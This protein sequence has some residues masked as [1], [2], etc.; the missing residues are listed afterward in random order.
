VLFHLCNMENK[1]NILDYLHFHIPTVEQKLALEALAQF[2]DIANKED[3]FILSGAAGTGKTS[4]TSALV[5]YLNNDI[6]YR[7]IAPTGRAARI[8]G[9]KTKCVSS[10]IHSLIYTPESN[11]E[12]G[13]VIWRLKQNFNDAYTVFIIDE[14]S[15]IASSTNNNE[16]FQ[17]SDSLLNHLVKFI[18]SGNPKNKIV[19]LGDKNQL[20]PYAE[21]DSLALDP[22]YMRKQY[23]FTGSFHY[24]TEVKRVEDGSY[25]LKNATRLRKSIEDNE[26]NIPKLEANRFNNTWNAAKDFASNYDPTNIDQLVAIGR[27]HKSN[28]IFNEEVRKKVFGTSVPYLIKD[29]LLIIQQ[30]WKR[31]D[32]VLFNGDHVIVEEVDLSKLETV[33]DLS[34]LPIKIKSISLD[35]SIQIIEDY[36]LLDT[37]LSENGQIPFEKEKKLRA[38]RF[39]KNKVYSSSGNIDDDKYVGAIRLGY[40]YSITCQKSQGGEWDKIYVNTFGIDDKRWLYTAITRAKN[41]LNLF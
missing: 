12:T 8:L 10:T 36:I 18:K 5:G 4:I 30:N 9:K 39:R 1:K 31:N 21:N 2:V 24:L 27:S 17:T 32:Q 33:C 40:G 34:F 28:K 35:G 37:L 13:S 14:S 19:L 16:M 11:I 25:I 22:N 20:P 6:Q 26:I 3:F 23:I 41:D 7:I 38:E 15:M 29:D